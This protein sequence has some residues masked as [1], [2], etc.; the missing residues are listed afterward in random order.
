M[1]ELSFYLAVNASAPAQVAAIRILAQREAYLARSRAL[2][3]R[4]RAI[5]D[6]WMAARDDV[7]WI[8]PAGGLIGFAR[9]H[10]VPNTAT[11]AARLLEEH[12]VALAAGEHFGVP[13]WARIGFGGE[14][15]KLREGLRRLSQALD[16]VR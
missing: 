1:K 13:G 2:A 10:R 16:E 15:A 3:T 7:S 9:L 11:F 14:E 8:P 12:D 5:V 6:E 4:G